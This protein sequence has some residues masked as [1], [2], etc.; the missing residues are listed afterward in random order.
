MMSAD[1]IAAFVPQ[2][3]K[4]RL[5]Y[6]NACN[7]EPV[8]K[9]LAKQVPFAIGS[10]LPLA[11]DQAI[12]GALSFYW[13]VLLGGTVLEAFQAARG[14]IGLLSGQ[15]AEVILHEQQENAASRVRLLPKPRILAA[16]NG[17]IPK[18]GK[19]FFEVTFGADGVPAETS[20]IVF[21]TDDEDVIDAGAGNAITA[22]LCAVARGRP[23]RAGAL[24]CDQLESWDIS[25]DFRLFAIGITSR[26]TK[27]TASSSLCEA[28][29]A[30]HG[31]EKR[32]MKQLNS[33]LNGLRQWGQPEPSR[34]SQGTKRGKRK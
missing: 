16:I 13:R 26:G 14:M 15:R 9:Q 3:Q 28:L 31:R 11:N 21:F 24:W 33:V 27:W 30:W 1:H 25:G 8:A 32:D 19:R 12:H 2:E 23:N 4:P 29:E 17:G 10:T 34:P 6:L 22:E 5:I 18:A 20:Q 7:S